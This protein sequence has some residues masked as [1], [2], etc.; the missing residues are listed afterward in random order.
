MRNGNLMG[1]SSNLCNPDHTLLRD[2]DVLEYSHF[3]EEFNY[4]DAQ[5]KDLAFSLR[6]GL[7][8]ARPLNVVLQGLPGTGK[9][10][11]VRTIFAEVEE[12]TKRI[13]PVY[14]NCHSEKTLFAV[15]SRI[16]SEL[17]GH[18]PPSLGNPR[19]DIL[20]RIG[21]AMV[22]RNIV[23]SVC[24]DDANYLLPD[25]VLN[26]VLSTLLR[27]NETYHDAKCGVI[28]TVS[29]TDT[30]FARELDPSVMSI[31]QP[32]E[33]V[34]PSYTR[35]EIHGI[36]KERAIR[37]FY[38]GTL[39]GPVLD[40]IVDRTTACGDLRV[41]LELLRRAAFLADREGVRV[42]GTPHVDA[43]FEFSRHVQIEHLTGLL[44]EPE[45]SLLAH[46]ARLVIRNPDSSLTMGMIYESAQLQMPL[47]YTNFHKRIRK[48]D[49]M[50]LINVHHRNTGR[51]GKTREITL[52]YDPKKVVEVCG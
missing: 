42:I 52:R 45:L 9:T 5:M 17:F 8:G 29:N 30:N 12:T 7:H 2:S 43:A 18:S 44:T 1:M 35:E 4:R 15:L 10:T 31:F 13:L 41:G 27:I 16:H 6:P 22:E 23:L 26:S 36:L 37:A 40:L 19:R 38:P 21:T 11:S 28:V 25:K 34:F 24:L 39:P 46:I 14:V 50:R 49:E 20:D 33:I 3:P 32:M 51:R 48:F 47:S